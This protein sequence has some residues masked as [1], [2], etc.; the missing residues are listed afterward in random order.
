M[1]EI[2]G[3]RMEAHRFDAPLFVR[4]LTFGR[5][6]RLF[7]TFFWNVPNFDLQWKRNAR[8]SVW[9]TCTD[10]Q[11]YSILTRQSWEA[12]AS[13][14]S[15]NGEKC[16]SVTVSVCPCNNGIFLLFR[17][18]SSIGNTAKLDPACSQLNAMNAADAAIIFPY[19]WYEPTL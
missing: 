17:P 4:E 7:Q 5:A 16:K 14:P 19:V 18:Q 3:G 12:V 2:I 15:W 8:H 6:Q 1:Q 13:R 11:K 9:A 10:V